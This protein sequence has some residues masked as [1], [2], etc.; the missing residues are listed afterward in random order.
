MSN[1][2]AIGRWHSRSR[3]LVYMAAVISTGLVAIAQAPE[4]Q[5]KD[6]TDQSHVD[7]TQE[8]SATSNKYLIETMGGGV[9]LFDY[10]NDG[11]LDIFF[12]NG[13]LLSDPMPE[14]RLP[15][16][17][18]KKFWNR[19]YHQNAD[20]TFTDVTEQAGLTGV[21]QG[22]YSMGVAVGDYDNDGFEDLYVTGFGGNVL[23]HNNGNGTFTDVTEKAGVKGGGWSASAGF[24]DYDNDGKLDLFVTRYLDWSFKT[25]RYCGE[26]PP[27]G[28]RS[29]CHP[30][31]Y[32]GVTNILYHNNGDGTFRDVSQKA[33]VANPRGKSLGVS[34]A[35]Y[36]GDGCLPASATTRMGR[37]SLVWELTSTIMTTMACRM[38][39]SRICRMKDTCCFAMKAPARFA[40]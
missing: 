6:I 5:F 8:N 26:R 17:S 24:F 1:G 29:Y 40:M 4:V 31:N 32:D 13:A 25:N 39:W 20:G 21:Q 30:D 18:D 22:Y 16:K 3:I 9:A 33:G 2:P 37:P 14:G 36:D 35:D 12:T 28:V 34:F 27:N 11:R 15:D 38:S 10:D 7:F 23:Y 19:L